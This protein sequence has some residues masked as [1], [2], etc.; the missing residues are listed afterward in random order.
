MT[1]F[2]NM[3]IIIEILNMHFWQLLIHRDLLQN[4]ETVCHRRGPYQMDQ[5][6]ED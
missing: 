1:C 6:Q 5:H 4:R 3:T 2:D